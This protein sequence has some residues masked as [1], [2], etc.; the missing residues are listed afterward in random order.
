MQRLRQA[1]QK[2]IQVPLRQIAAQLKFIDESGSNLGLTRLFGRAAPGERVIEGTPGYSGKH[3]TLVAALGLGTVTAT[4]L[5]EGA[6]TQEAFEIYVG[7]VLA[8][9]LQAG[10]VVLIDNLNVHKSERTA[11]LIAA[12]GARLQFLPPYSSDLNPMELC[13]AKVK[14]VLRKLKARTFDELV[15]ALG[16]AF[17]SI[18][19]KDM[20]AWFAHCGYLIP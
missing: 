13:W 10:D 3:Y 20:Q 4:W 7:A 16:V 2:K 12:R 6:M 1:F 9:T 8:P 11:R 17:E 14:T 19:P 18:T 5:L 15:A